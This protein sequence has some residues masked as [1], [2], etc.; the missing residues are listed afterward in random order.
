MTVSRLTG[1]TSP[2][3]NSASQSGCWPR[4]SSARHC[5]FRTRFP[6]ASPSRR[7]LPRRPARPN[8]LPCTRDRR[9]PAR[10]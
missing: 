9:Q 5:T 8:T 2:T 1:T 6:Q 4:T 7:R 3:A 10:P